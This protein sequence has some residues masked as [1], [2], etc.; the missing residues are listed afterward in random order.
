MERPRQEVITK[1]PDKEQNDE[2]RIYIIDITEEIQSVIYQLAEEAT[3]NYI[4]SLKERQGLF[5]KIIGGIKSSF[6]E[7]SRSYIYHKFKKQIETEVFNNYNIFQKIAIEGRKVNIS[8]TD[9]GKMS[10]F[11]K[12]AIDRFESKVADRF[13]RDIEVGRKIES[14][15]L[16]ELQNLIAEIVKDFITQPDLDTPQG[17]I[18]FNQAFSQR[19]RELI[20]EE[21]LSSDLFHIENDRR[22]ADSPEHFSTNIYDYVVQLRRELGNIANENNL[23]PEQQQSLNEYVQR[24]TNLDIQVGRLTSSIRTKL[25]DAGKKGTSDYTL[26]TIERLCLSLEN[27]PILNKL[28]NPI[29]VGLA[30]G[31]LSREGLIKIGGR[32][33][34]AAAGATVIGSLG[35]LSFPIITGSVLGGIFAYFRSKARVK[36]DVGRIL[37]EQAAGLEITDKRAQQILERIALPGGEDFRK[38]IYDL[39]RDIKKGDENAKNAYVEAIARLELEYETRTSED[40]P[41]LD[42]LINQGIWRSSY[43]E[44][45][46]LE[47]TILEFESKLSEEEKTELRKRA[48]EEKGSLREK[49]LQQDQKIK[50]ESNKIAAR[51]GVITGVA[52][53]VLGSTV[54]YLRDLI[55]ETA[56]GEK[57]SEHPLGAIISTP[58]AKQRIGLIEYL[59]GEKPRPGR[60]GFTSINING[61]E[62][63]V[64]HSQRE[65]FGERVINLPDGHY[66][67]I[68]WNPESQQWTL[69]L[70]KEAKDAGWAITEDGFYLE[71]KGIHGNLISTWTEIKDILSQRGYKTTHVSWD[72]FAYERRPPLRSSWEVPPDHPSFRSEGFELSLSYRKAPD[73]SVIVSVPVK[74]IAFR[75]GKE[76]DIGEFVE[77]GKA[78]ITLSPR[79]RLLQH[80]AL[81]FSVGSENIKGSRAEITIP[82][83]IADLFFYEDNGK[84]KLNSSQITYGLIEGNEGGKL[85]LV[86][87]AADYNSRGILTEILPIKENVPINITEHAPIPPKELDPPIP[88]PPL[89]EWKTTKPGEYKRPLIVRPPEAPYYYSGSYFDAL[90]WIRRFGLNEELTAKEKQELER[91]KEELLELEKKRAKLRIIIQE[92]EKIKEIIQ[93]YSQEDESVKTEL[94]RQKEELKTQTLTKIQ[95]LEKEIGEL[96]DKT[97]EES[98]ELKEKEEELQELRELLSLLEDLENLKEETL[99]TKLETKRKELKRLRDRIYRIRKRMREINLSIELKL[100]NRHIKNM[101]NVFNSVFNK[102][103]IARLFQLNNYTGEEYGGFIKHLANQIEPMENNCRVSIFIPAYMEGENICKTLEKYTRQVDNKNQPLD[104]SLYEIVILVNKRENEEWDNTQTEIERF[105]GEHPEVRIRALVCDFPREIASVGLARRILTDVI[106]FRSLQREEQKH[107]LY[108]ITEDADLMEVDEKIVYA[109]ITRFERYPWLDALRGLQVR[110]PELLKLNHMLWLSRTGSQLIEYLMRPHQGFEENW[111]YRVEPWPDPFS[112]ARVITGGWATNFTASALALI[113]GY[114]PRMKA[115]ED[116]FVGNAISIARSKEYDGNNNPVPNL[117]TIKTMPVAHVS[118]MRRFLFEFFRNVYGEFGTPEIEGLIR[119]ANKNNVLYEIEEKERKI[120]KKS[121]FEIII[122]SHIGTLLNLTSPNFTEGRRRSEIYLRL[123]YLR[124]NKDYQWKDNGREIEL[125]DSGVRRLE[126]LFDLNKIFISKFGVKELIRRKLGIWP[127]AAG[128]K[129]PSRAD[130]AYELIVLINEN[131]PENSREDLSEETIKGLSENE[132]V[133]REN[134]VINQYM[135]LTEEEKSK[136]VEKIVTKRT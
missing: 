88:I 71:R 105:K 93:N 12:L 110:D 54:Q 65:F 22:I 41:Q 81:I 3:A 101:D 64:F 120:G 33:L 38:N 121:F 15:N 36:Q 70:S 50:Q 95:Q 74:G 16:G 34:A 31:I 17:R 76:W 98:G 4:N 28:V 68:K 10:D 100:I 91:L 2:K 53:F 117:E 106:L 21:K 108:L 42:L 27:V 30:T 19:I 136:I 84:L 78:C 45:Y 103:T 83:E 23:T 127:I 66:G 72:D 115:G 11:L 26:S 61:Q 119:T 25:P 47:Q 129:V 63:N 134:R 46:Q 1:K 132:L 124:E 37:R 52:A 116:I 35:Y 9:I 20:S 57:L 18:R 32:G 14:Q 55:G 56:V 89:I 79:D 29:T 92:L 123:F 82:K 118:S 7:L 58:H 102:E 107:P 59:L 39:I 85:K 49:I 60:E 5:G 94:L 130:N 40:L 133:E 135:S 96:R 125:L 73:G 99:N 24:I 114:D 126:F 75:P 86:S 122:N 112:W 80:D 67:T 51:N 113:G 128:F 104:P 77:Q 87:V 43:I 131:L 90:N 48:D 62:L 111:Y 109:T 13:S 97:S 8:E 69:E 6:A 44:K